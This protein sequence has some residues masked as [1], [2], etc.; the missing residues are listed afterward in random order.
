MSQISRVISKKLTKQ[1]SKLSEVLAKAGDDLA[2]AVRKRT[3]QG[4]GVSRNNGIKR[5]LKQLASSTIKKRSRLPLSPKT[6]PSKSNLTQSG[7]MLDSIK[8]DVDGTQIKVT[9]TGAK[10]NKKAQFVS[11]DRPFLNLSKDEVDAIKRQIKEDFI[12]KIKQSL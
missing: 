8:A 2:D 7:S 6:T 1:L 9:I 11:K 10:N 12:R 5:S 4:F 3:R